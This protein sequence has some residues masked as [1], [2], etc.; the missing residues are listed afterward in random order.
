MLWRQLR[1]PLLVLLLAA[2]AVSGVTGDPTDA[3]II[4]VIV[5]L[6]VGLGFFNEYRSEKAVEALHS[7]IRQ[8]ALVIRDGAPRRST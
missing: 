1:N 6:S 8:N 4:A 2:A 3:L 7:Q 5:G